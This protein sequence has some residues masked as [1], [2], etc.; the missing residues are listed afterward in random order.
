MEVN[1]DKVEFFAQYWGQNVFAS[2]QWKPYE[3]KEGATVSYHS[4]TSADSFYSYLL[5]KP[6]SSISDEDA[7]LLAESRGY[8]NV[9]R[10]YV[11]RGG[12]FIEWVLNNGK[13]KHRFIQF[14]DMYQP[15]IDFLR[16]KG[17]ALPFRGYSVEQMIALGWIKLKDNAD[18]K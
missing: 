4:I 17:Y 1:K 18:K 14:V 8:V 2:T 9:S 12:Y 6:L 5:L 10:A 15:E 13:L 7:M 16:S 3:Q 11:N